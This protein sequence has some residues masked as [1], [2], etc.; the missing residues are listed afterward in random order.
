MIA[1]KL[2]KPCSSSAN[3]IRKRL[4][5]T[6]HGAAATKSVDEAPRQ[7]Y[8]DHRLIVHR[9]S[10]ESNCVFSAESSPAGALQSR[11]NR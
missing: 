3:R 9:E 8:H 7:I 11:T 10:P 4:S 6:R 5:K 1:W 2:S